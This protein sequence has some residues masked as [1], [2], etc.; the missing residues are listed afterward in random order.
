MPNG[1]ISPYQQ[2]T[3]AIQQQ[4]GQ[5]AAPFFRT[6]QAAQAPQAAPIDQKR[7]QWLTQARQLNPN[8]DEQTLSNIY[9]QKVVPAQ[10]AGRDPWETTKVAEIREEKE[11]YQQIKNNMIPP[12]AGQGQSALLGLERGAKDL[13]QG[14]MEEMYQIRESDI[15]RKMANVFSAMPGFEAFKLLNAPVPQGTTATY[16]DK[17]NKEITQYEAQTKDHPITAGAM[18]LVGGLL[19]ALPMGDTA[20]GA[21]ILQQSITRRMLASGTQ[22]AALGSM[23]YDP[24]G[25]SRLYNTILAGFLG[26]AMGGTFKGFTSLYKWIKGTPALIDDPAVLN[27]AADRV[28]EAK[29]LGLDQLTAGAATRLPT[30]QN[31]ESQ[32]LKA[33]GPGADLFRQAHE[34]ISKQIH[35]AGQNMIKAVG[36]TPVMDKIASEQ[37]LKNTGGNVQTAID[38]LRTNIGYAVSNMYQEAGTAPG[39]ATQ[40]DRSSILSAHND[41]MN[42]FTDMKFSPA[43][44]KKIENLSQTTDY[45]D[46]LNPF[47][48]KDANQLVQSLNKAYRATDKQPTRAAISILKSNVFDALDKLAD[49]KNNPSATLFNLARQTR[50][51]LGNLYDNGNIVA[52][53]KQLRGKSNTYIKPE[54]VAQKIFGPKTKISD[55]NDVENAL[56]YIPPINKWMSEAKRLNPGMDNTQLQQI[57]EGQIIPQATKGRDVWNDI[58][59]AKLNDIMTKATIY[60]NGVPHLDYRR[61][62]NQWSQV[63]KAGM[64]KLWG[65][66]E[67]S[68]KFSSLLSIMDSFQN[69]AKTAPNIER[70]GNSLKRLVNSIFVT[71]GGARDGGAELHAI[72]Y[73]IP[74]IGNMLRQIADE[75]WVKSNLALGQRIESDFSMLIKKEPQIV[76]SIMSRL[77][78]L[79]L[80]KPQSVEDVNQMNQQL[81]E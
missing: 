50:R 5:M 78:A 39:W 27:A 70:A 54:E 80:F 75:N 59:A 2:Q 62:I 20:D 17:V 34:N 9:D 15:G 12:E 66:K 74:I 29:S 35:E 45:K 72:S 24:T 77:A 58:R 1:T 10:M 65:T 36:G 14:L 6:P 38:A 79:S 21:N 68:D 8:V 28:K 25:H 69:K 73:H 31:V 42:D 52:T 44:T 64:E 53:I 33:E 30:I 60:D 56:T 57:Y 23:E 71:M 51:E 48:V 47:S 22:T 49:D 37:V 81:G 3:Q 7:Q 40:V 13:G 76:S 41:I 4:Y 19:V 16:R 26:S 18:R 63:G 43:I 61:L 46:Y 55:L 67:L 32:M 11:G